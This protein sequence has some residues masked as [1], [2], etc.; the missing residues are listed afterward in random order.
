MRYVGY[1]ASLGELVK[2]MENS[3]ILGLSYNAV[4][5][6]G[7]NVEEEQIKRVLQGVGILEKTKKRKILT[8]IYLY[9]EGLVT[10]RKLYRVLP[11]IVCTLT[12]R[13]D[14]KK[15]LAYFIRTA[16]GSL[17]DLGWGTLTRLLTISFFSQMPT[18]RE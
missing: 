10:N 1:L 11:K 5:I 4:F 8:P 7:E 3:K 12:S 9:F 13:V 15:E 18:K 16:V 6:D 14:C 2:A 17:L